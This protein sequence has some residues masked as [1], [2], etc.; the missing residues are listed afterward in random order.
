MQLAYEQQ[1]QAFAGMKA[2]AGDDFVST[3]S[4]QARHPFGLALVLASGN[5]EL[6][7]KLPSVSTDITDL[8]AFRGVALHSHVVEQVNDGLAPGYLAKTPISVMEKGNCWVVVAEDVTPSS[9]V[10]CVYS[11]ADA[12]KFGASALSATAAILPNAR[13]RSNSITVDGVKIACLELY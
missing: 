13:Y 5:L 4:S 1:K 12:G 6:R 2:D 8:K 7:G 11:G 3:Y 9:V 10:Y